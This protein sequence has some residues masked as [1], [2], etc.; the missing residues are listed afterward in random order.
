MQYINDTGNMR[1]THSLAMSQELTG[2][3]ICIQ[4]QAL[5]SMLSL[6]SDKRLI[7][8][9]DAMV[10]DYAVLDSRVSRKHM[11]ITYIGALNKYRIVDYSSN[12]VFLQDGSR[13]VKNKEYYLPPGTE[14][15]LGQGNNRYKLK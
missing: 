5:G 12:G 8:G 11:E 7:V 13:L 3:M 6:K 14:I 4:G 2:A 1:V 9:R 10:C 15:N